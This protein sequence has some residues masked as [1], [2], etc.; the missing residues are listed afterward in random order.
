MASGDVLLVHGDLRPER[1]EEIELVAAATGFSANFLT[2]PEESIASLARAKPKA[3][4]VDAASDGAAQVCRRVRADRRFLNTPVLAIGPEATKEQYQRVFG[5][6]ADDLVPY[7]SAQ[8]LRVRLRGFPETEPAP[9]KSRGIAIVADPDRAR[10]VVVG[11]TLTLAG[12]QV[13]YADDGDSLSSR[14]EDP[15]V[16]I[17]IADSAIDELSLRI[18]TA[19]GDRMLAPWIVTARNADLAELEQHL[20]QFDSVVVTWAGGPA[21]NLLFLVNELLAEHTAS[22]RAQPRMLYGTVVSFKRVG[23][24]PEHGFT[25]NISR[26]GLYVRT[27]APPTDGSV[28]LELTPPGSERPVRLEAR[29]VW[30]RHFGR[31]GNETTPPGFGAEILDS[32]GSALSDW[33]RCYSELAATTPQ[34]VPPSRGQ[35]ITAGELS[36]GLQGAPTLDIGDF[37]EGQQALPPGAVEPDAPPPAPPV[38]AAPPAPPVSPQAPAA[39]PE[40]TAAF[41]EPVPAVG[42]PP[43]G[44]PPPKRISATVTLAAVAAATVIGGVGSFSVVSMMKDDPEPTASPQTTVAAKPPSTP[45]QTAAAAPSTTATA[46]A[47]VAPSSTVAPLASAE[48]ATDIP[49]AGAQPEA[50]GSSKKA[51]FTDD[52]SALDPRKGHLI[53]DSEDTADV[54]VHGQKTGATNSQLTVTCGQRWVRL[55]RLPGPA[56]ISPGQ[57]ALVKCQGTT[58]INLN[59]DAKFRAP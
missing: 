13:R 8:A 20:A 43:A 50:T 49:D 54:W 15:A 56:W 3:V 23:G 2:T 42:E 14:L 46:S 16:G 58:R 27:L 18:A 17:V 59:V 5:W 29:V 51:Q 28:W 35:I 45:T 41:S 21:E 6:G 38:A 10:C 33:Q 19:R 7:R 31:T 4:L 55:G 39:P 25:Y 40:P 48:P 44:V 1:R 47:P 34:S 37:T 12:Y 11:R 32:L 30:A 24:K 53:V 57:S 26:S 22:G 9:A 36:L 52:G